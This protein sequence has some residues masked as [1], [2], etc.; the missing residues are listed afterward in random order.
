MI[1]ILPEHAPPNNKKYKLLIADDVV[2]EFDQSEAVLA[3]NAFAEDIVCDV[4]E[5]QFSG[6]LKGKIDLQ[7]LKM[8]L[9]FMV[10]VE[11]NE[12]DEDKHYTEML[13]KLVIQKYLWEIK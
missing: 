10:V 11:Q 12:I 9:N 4:F 6:L 13:H 3:L 8:A 1:S 7:S 2:T 5:L